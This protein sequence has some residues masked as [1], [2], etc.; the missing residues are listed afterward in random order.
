MNQ[1]IIQIIMLLAVLFILRLI[2]GF[3]PKERRPKL[4]PIDCL[5]LLNLWFIWQLSYSWIDPWFAAVVFFWMVISIVLTLWWGLSKGELLWN[6]FLLFY[7]R[8]SD[9]LL[10]FAYFFTVVRTLIK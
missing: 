10:I 4:Q 7:R 9:I 2:R 6:K 5:P 8:V 3:I 1:I